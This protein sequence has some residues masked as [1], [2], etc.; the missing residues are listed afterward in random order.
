MTDERSAADRATDTTHPCDTPDPTV[1]GTVWAAPAAPTWPPQ[2]EVQGPGTPSDQAPT[3]TPRRTEP[4]SATRAESPPQETGRRGPR[5]Y[6]I[7]IGILALLVAGAATGH[8]TGMVALDWSVFG[9]TALLLAGVLLVVIGV[10]G[11]LRRR[12]AR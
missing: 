1:D 12:T 9:P 8:H 6:P 3:P 4:P 2:D 10:V 7:L 5:G 11:L